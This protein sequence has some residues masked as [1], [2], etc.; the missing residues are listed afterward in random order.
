MPDDSQPRS[1]RREFISQAIA[2]GVITVLAAAQEVLPTE[3]A[4]TRPERPVVRVAIDEA[5]CVSEWGQSF[6]VEYLLLRDALAKLGR[7]PVLLLTA[8]APPEVRRDVV[9]QLGIDLDLDHGKDL[10]LDYWRKDELVPSVVCVRGLSRKYRALR[11]FVAA[12]GPAT[13][14]I[15]YTRFATAGENDDRENVREISEWLERKGFGPVAYYHGQLDPATPV[16]TPA[17]ILCPVSTAQS[18]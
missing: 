18:T 8:T 17:A 14:G 10:I 15:V 7:P 1:L 4:L 16:W 3:H 9:T 12:Q 13:R 11:D 2:F 5:H 6:R